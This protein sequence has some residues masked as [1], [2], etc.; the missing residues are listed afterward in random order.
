[1][2]TL[3]NAKI[4]VTDI[5]EVRSSTTP[6]VR[7]ST[8]PEL[9]EPCF[10]D[11]KEVTAVVYCLDCDETFC[12]VCGHYHKKSKISKDLKFFNLGAAPPAHVVQ[13]M[14]ELTTCPNHQSEDVVYI[15]VDEDQL[16]CNQ[17]ANT[18][19]RQCRRVEKIDKCL[20]YDIVKEISCALEQK[21]H[22]QHQQ[23]ALSQHW[24]EAHN[25]GWGYSSN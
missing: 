18:S 4:P 23:R 15:C 16:C 2:A 10:S 17:L 14:K 12:V 25:H 21:Q 13:L 8:T 22:N 11:C 1:M 24:K 9:C 7:S 3:F 19:H 5:D 20:K 6:E